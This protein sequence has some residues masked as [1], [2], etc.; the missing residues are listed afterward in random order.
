[1]ENLRLHFESIG[2]IGD[3]LDSIID[4]FE[5]KEFKKNDFIVEEGKVSKHIGIV[6]SGILH[7]YTVKEGEEKTHYISVTNTWFA[8]L[9]SFLCEAPALENMTVTKFAIL[10]NG[11]C[12]FVFI[13]S[14]VSLFFS[15]S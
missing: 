13:S 2:F 4:A 8:S 12:A 3:S 9:L 7:Y 11:Y 10:P 15:M 5:I 1:M 14:L 6:K